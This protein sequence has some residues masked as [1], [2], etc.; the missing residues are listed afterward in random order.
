MYG[1]I[2]TRGGILVLSMA[3]S[4][5]NNSLYLFVFYFLLSLIIVFTDKRG[6]LADLH[7]TVQGFT[8]PVESRLFA[9][10]RTLL[11]PFSLFFSTSDKDK[12]IQELE[13]ENTLLLGQLSQLAS[14][15]EENIKARYLLG[16]SLPPSWHFEP[17]R[18]TSVFADKMFL[19]SD[20]KPEVG[21]PVITQEDKA[22]VLVGQVKE[23]VGKKTVVTLP[24]NTLFKITA[25]A[26]DKE[27]GGRHGT[28]ILVG[29]GAGMILEQ[30][31]TSETI[32]EGDLV[33]SAGDENLPPELLVGYVSRVHDVKGAFKEAEVKPAVDPTKLDF[34]FLVTKW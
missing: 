10:R 17:A 30:V 15:E 11:S 22:G 12:R 6:L 2:L 9:L 1:T 16:A 4:A 29:R 33:V 19:V 8:I 14:V 18:V 34:V 20:A 7:R 24:M 31:L 23:I 26:R 28:G 13:K 21:T 5:K 3:G 32:E 25:T 27:T